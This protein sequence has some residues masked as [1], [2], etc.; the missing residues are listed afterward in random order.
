MK[1][2]EGKVALVTGAS[3]G[4]GRAIALRF[5][6]EGARI[7]VNYSQSMNSA[8]V[9]VKEIEDSGGEAIARKANVANY[10]EVADM[11]AIIVKK[12]GTIHILVNNAGMS[13][14]GDLLS[15]NEA[16]LLEMFRVNVLG[17]IN[18][19]KVA[20][21]QMVDQR[22]GKIVNIGSIAGIGTN[23][24]G[25]TPYAS[26]KASILVLT[27]RFAL[28]LGPSGVNV[29]SILPGFIETEMNTR[30]KTKEEW[31]NK[32]KEMSEKAMLRRIG[33]PQDIANAAVFLAS[34]EA[35]FITGQSLVIDGGRLDF[36][37]HSG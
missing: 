25:T 24:P 3:R 20:A 7:C 32:T 37:S 21:R 14:P 9:V 23:F 12:F 22:Y 10:N 18:C 11:V 6:S 31:S 35:S 13:I 26:T 2:L 30:G 8:E 29:N 34:D 4:I 27:K 5:A 33:Q 1:P 19:S 17:T 16:Q 15:M 28:E 36:L